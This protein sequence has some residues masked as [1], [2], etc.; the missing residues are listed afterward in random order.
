MRQRPSQDYADLCPRESAPRAR[1]VPRLRSSPVR[2]RSAWPWQY[3]AARGPRPQAAGICG[4]LDRCDH[5]PRS[6]LAREPSAL[7]PEIHIRCHGRRAQWR[8]IPPTRGR[9]VRPARSLAPWPV[10]A[11]CGVTGP[12]LLRRPRISASPAATGCA[13]AYQSVLEAACGLSRRL[14]AG[15]SL[16]DQ[17]GPPRRSG[18]H[19]PA[20]RRALLSFHRRRPGRDQ[21]RSPGQRTGPETGLWRPGKFSLACSP[22]NASRGAAPPGRRGTGCRYTRWAI[23]RHSR[24]FGP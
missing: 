24:A 11:A 4:V 19:V 2:S 8:K 15:R 22:F 12:S 13:C 23:H 6:G 18:R 14:S 1:P 10:A 7:A 5:R 9:P 16:T 20:P 3:F 17:P 21:R